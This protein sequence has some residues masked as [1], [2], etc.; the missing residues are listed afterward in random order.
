MTDAIAR[1]QKT[2]EGRC[3]IERKL[4]PVF[5]LDADRGTS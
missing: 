3:A 4:R 1:L 5:A 2:L